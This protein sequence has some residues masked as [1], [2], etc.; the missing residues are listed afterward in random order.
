MTKPTQNKVGI[1]C[2]PRCSLHPDVIGWDAANKLAAA[3][4]AGFG[5]PRFKRL[6]DEILGRPNP[7]SNI[8]RHLQHYVMAVEEPDEPVTSGKKPGDIEILDSIITQGFRNSKNWKPTIRDTL[9]AMKLKTQ[10]TGNSAFEDLI[11]LFDADDEGEPLPENPEAVL[12]PDELPDEHDEELEE[13]LG[14][15]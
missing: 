13:P 8:Q 3:R 5:L 11:A 15:L 14:G 7:S 6:A 10:M 12:S 4:A 9:E 1:N 2:P